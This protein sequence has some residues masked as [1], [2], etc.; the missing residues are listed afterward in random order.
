MASCT[1]ALL[2]ALVSAQA[3]GSDPLRDAVMLKS[4]DQLI[5]ITTRL[6]LAVPDG[7]SDDA[8]RAI[9][10]EGAQDE[11]PAHV[12]KKRWDG[13]DMPDD[14]AAEKAAKLK[15]FPAESSKKPAQSA[16]P[17]TGE[18]RENMEDHTFK[19]LDRDSDGKLS[20]EEMSPI[21]ERTNAEARAK[22]EQV[23]AD[24]FGTLDTDADGYVSRAELSAFFRRLEGRSAQARRATDGADDAKAEQARGLFRNLDQNKDGKLDRAEM[25]KII[26][27]Y[28][29][30]RKV[31]TRAAGP[32]HA[33]TQPRVHPPPRGRRKARMRLTSSL[34]W[35][36]MATG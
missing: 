13:S 36:P 2:A 29:A 6:G 18:A 22:G 24:F 33:P 26:D 30:Q 28:N 35:T 4:H 10:Y 14:E 12:P 21:I 5:E 23:P 1:L 31:R 34:R 7:A 32:C 11:K 27:G 20:R 15:V 16:Q 17:A 9:I 8:I 3:P 25:K 19:A